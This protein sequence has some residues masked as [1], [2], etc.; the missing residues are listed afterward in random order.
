MADQQPQ[1]LKVQA[2]KII[3][4]ACLDIR[5]AYLGGKKTL[6]F[7]EVKGKEQ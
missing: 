4:V 7:L 3:P 6:I 2:I 1:K 5:K